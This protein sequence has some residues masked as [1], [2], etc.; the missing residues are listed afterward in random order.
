MKAGPKIQLIPTAGA[1]PALVDE[2]CDLR[3]R[4]KAWRPEV[5]PI[6]ARYAEVS[7]LILAA[8]ESHPAA[9]PIIAHGRR[10]DL[11]ITARRIE[12]KISNLAGFF[13][14]IGRDKFLEVCSLTLGAVEREIPKDKLNLYISESQTGHRTIGEPVA[15]QA[16]EARLAA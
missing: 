14:K 1:D 6:A 16:I 12:R 10:F 8:Y 7:A 11:P 13:R 9:A 3:E 4:M 5:N 2:Y 15:R